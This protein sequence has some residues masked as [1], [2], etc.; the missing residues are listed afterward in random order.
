GGGS[1]A[2]GR[3]RPAAPGGGAVHVEFADRHLGARERIG[4][5]ARNTR[6]HHEGRSATFAD[7]VVAE[8]AAAFEARAAAGIRP[9]GDRWQH[10]VRVYRGGGRCLGRRRYACRSIGATT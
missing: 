2:G 10:I 6:H 8:A 7:R 5:A 3:Q 1:T 9:V 4:L